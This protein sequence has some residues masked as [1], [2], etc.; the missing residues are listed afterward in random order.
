M[1]VITSNAPA[2]KVLITKSKL[3]AAFILCRSALTKH[4][5]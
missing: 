1:C 5:M 3:F 2:M 4:T